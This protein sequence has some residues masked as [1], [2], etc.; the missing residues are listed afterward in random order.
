[1]LATGKQTV[2]VLIGSCLLACGVPESEDSSLSQKEPTLEERIGAQ[3]N[4]LKAK[5]SLHAK[6]LPSGREI[7]IRADEPMN[8]VS[9]I[10]LAIMV[11]AYRDTETKR[12][13]LRERY[14]L[15]SED[16][17]GG[18]GVLPSFESG[19]RPTYRDLITQMIITSDNTATDILI[20]KVGLDRV[21]DMLAELGYEETRL[22][23]TLAARY[24]R[25]WE[26]LDPALAALSD[27]EVFERG[28]PSDL[29]SRERTFALNADPAEWLGRTTARE[30]SRL[31]EQIHNGDLT[32]RPF[33]DEMIEILKKQRSNSR[34][35]RQIRFQG[36]VVAHKTG[37][38]PPSTANDVGIIY[39]EGGPTIV[40]VFTNE[41]RGSFVELEETIGS[42][43][44]D[45]IL[46]WR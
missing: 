19:L 16:K 39:Y 23:G 40:S 13:D 46:E 28:F 8:S 11:L 12:L 5:I 42:I 32:S 31:L 33:S 36:A 37:D 22:Q 25:R 45:L 35:P 2:S 29:A 10:K 7:A 1:M 18:S 17:R 27:L 14:V 41:N 30:T 21:N 4:G 38:S 3:I 6:H 26:V 44:Q 24:R 15:R 9:V 20:N 43:A 34:L